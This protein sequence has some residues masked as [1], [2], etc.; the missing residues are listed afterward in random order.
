[1]VCWISKCIMKQGSCIAKPAVSEFVLSSPHGTHLFAPWCP[2]CCSL[3]SPSSL[4]VFLIWAASLLLLIPFIKG[5]CSLPLCFHSST[6]LNYCTQCAPATVPYQGWGYTLL[7]RV[8]TLS[9]P[10]KGKWQYQVTLA[11]AYSS[12]QPLNCG[13]GTWV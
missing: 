5:W 1:M 2:S 12:M 13:I 10:Q 3:D 4:L 11:L 6:C 8:Y 9:V 7:Q